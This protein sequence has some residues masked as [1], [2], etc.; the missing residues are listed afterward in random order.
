MTYHTVAFT[1]TITSTTPV[2]V[3]AVQDTILNTVNNR[4]LPGRDYGLIYSYVLGATV[5]EARLDSPQ[6]R[7]VIL[8][9]FQKIDRNATPSSDPNF[10][11]Y[12][13]NPFKI[14][15]L[16]E[17]QPQT[18]NDGFGEVNTVIMGLRDSFEPIPSGEIWTM[19][20]TSTTATN[21][22]EWTTITTTWS[23]ELPAG[24]WALVGGV[25]QSSTALAYRW[26]IEGQDLRPG[27]VAITAIGNR[28]SEVFYQGRLGVLGR[29]SAWN[30]PRV[31]M[32]ETG[33]SSDIDVL[34]SFMRLPG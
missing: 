2:G 22:N 18:A 20:G 13:Q 9:H 19:R 14:R 28:T 7:A 31:Q 11:D 1:A 26:V 16:E 21:A 4:I 30:P 29:F 17:F 3:D 10:N 8:P 5:N 32:L 6:A 27:G 33:A 24:K 12:S 34:M 23:D 25:A 15:G